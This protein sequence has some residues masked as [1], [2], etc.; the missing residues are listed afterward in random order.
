MRGKSYQRGVKGDTDVEVR[1][2]PL[3]HHRPEPP[4]TPFPAAVHALACFS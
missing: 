3:G 4:P 1:L 2:L